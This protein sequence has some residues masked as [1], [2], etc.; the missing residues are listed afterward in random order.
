MKNILLCVAFALSGF[1]LFAQRIIPLSFTIHEPYN[2]QIVGYNKE[3]ALS[4]TI[5]N[6]SATESLNVNDT[7]V[8]TFTGANR[9]LGI[10]LDKPVGPGQNLRLDSIILFSNVNSSKQDQTDDF[11]IMLLG[12]A[13]VTLVGSWSNPFY[14]VEECV[15]ITME[16]NNRDAA[17]VPTA[18]YFAVS[19][20]NEYKSP[21]GKYVWSTSGT[22]K[23]TIQNVSGCDSLLTI[24]LNVQTIDHSVTITEQS[25]M[26][27]MKG[28]SYQ[29]I[30]CNND[31]LPI[32]DATEREFIPTLSGRYA[33]VLTENDCVDTS[34]C[35]DFKMSSSFVVDKI[36]NATFIIYP[37]PSQGI[38]Q[39]ECSLEGSKIVELLSFS[40]QIVSRTRM[41]GHHATMNLSPLP[42]GIYLIKIGS[43]FG[44]LKQRITLLP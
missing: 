23:D 43:N 42:A 36:N 25:L 5:I 18:A 38:I 1:N 27:N 21:S 14:L 19:T 33:V 16:G 7:I 2:N 6:T 41:E 28:M 8:C 15:S 39:L 26:A 9:Y 24:M 37:N 17:C 22:Y 4:L 31:N 40:G 13:N 29:W 11:C 12:T 20:C 3:F 30:D 35:Y 32:P 44:N 34:L 10:I